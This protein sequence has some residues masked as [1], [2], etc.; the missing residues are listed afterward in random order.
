MGDIAI[1]SGGSDRTERSN[2]YFK[3]MR[4]LVNTY[5]NDGGGFR[6]GFIDGTNIIDFK[7]GTHTQGAFPG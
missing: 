4:E 5:A 7:G 1:P 2:P 3:K 6:F